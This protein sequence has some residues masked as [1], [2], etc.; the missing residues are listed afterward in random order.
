[1]ETLPDFTTSSVRNPHSFSYW[2]ES[3]TWGGN[4]PSSQD[5][6]VIPA[7]VTMIYDGELDADIKTLI[8]KSGG[9]LIFEEDDDCI[10]TVQNFIIEEGGEVI[11]GTEDSPIIGRVE[12]I[13]RGD[14]LDPTKDPNQYG[15]GLLV[16]GKL[17]ACGRF[18]NTSIKIMEDATKDQN[19]LKVEYIPNNWI[20]GDQ[21]VIPPSGGKSMFFTPRVPEIVNMQW[22][23][24]DDTL[25]IDPPLRESHMLG[26]DSK[27]LADCYPEVSN[28]ERS[29]IFRSRD[30]KGIRGHIMIMDDADC[31]LANVRF[32]DL[33]RTTDDALG[34]TNLAGRYPIH[35]HRLI[36]GTSTTNPMRRFHRFT[37][38]GCVIQDSLK[39]ACVVHDSHCGLVINNTI[40]GAQH[41]GIVT[42]E[43]SESYNR[44]EG[45]RVYNI[46]RGDG[47][48]L[49]GIHNYINHNIA[50]CCLVNHKTGMGG[51]GF[52]LP[53]NPDVRK[54]FTVP[55]P[56]TDKTETWSWGWGRMLECDGNEVYGC[57]AGF[58]LDHS[59]AE[60]HITDFRV[61]WGYGN[62]NYGVACAAY[63]TGGVTYD[64][65]VARG[66]SM[67]IY[68]NIATNLVNCDIQG[69]DIG[70]RDN[71]QNGKLTITSCL[72]CNDLNVKIILS[73]GVGAGPFPTKAL[74]ETYLTNSVFKTPTNKSI[75]NIELSRLFQNEES[76]TPVLLNV[77]GVVN[78]NGVNGD[79]FRIYFEE[80]EESVRVPYEGDIPPN[81]IFLRKGSPEPGLSN[82]ECW[83]KYNLAWA[84]A[85]APP[86]WKIR[87]GIVGLVVGGL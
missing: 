40:Y 84:G 13:F 82:K 64:R 17:T 81:P 29:I 77:I 73:P 57:R 33:G 1:M 9:V 53:P 32:E 60:H 49:N 69:C 68:S 74:K 67:D 75:R 86:S 20:S 70:V 83:A 54:K 52:Y 46:V 58:W 31:L 3:K 16:K 14:P 66:C 79:S 38:E 42:E 21:L 28:L 45:N 15:C 6:V 39:W 11:I 37:L 78:Y 7:N 27:G 65:V 55:I 26:R 5:T 12:I 48:W 43:G 63:D 56:L 80:Q 72:L 41:A 71:S 22:F 8:V 25:G 18:R 10:L 30:R 2:S 62:I 36:G 50:A 34:S 59:H 87:Q 19:Y 76:R 44:I 4:F 61:W 24:D 85:V 35:F 51:N 23:K 47:Y